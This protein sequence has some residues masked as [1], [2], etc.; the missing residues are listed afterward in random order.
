VYYRYKRYD[1]KVYLG[2]RR[3]AT[4]SESYTLN[5]KSTKILH[6]CTNGR[7]TMVAGTSKNVPRRTRRIQLKDDYFIIIIIIIFSIWNW[8]FRCVQRMTYHTIALRIVVAIGARLMVCRGLREP[9]EIHGIARTRCVNTVSNR[10]RYRV[11][12]Y[13]NHRAS[14]IH[15]W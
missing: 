8:E 2:F 15:Y 10:V 9:R 14:V 11:Y 4:R 7:I 5:W 13:A 12:L 3:L 6:H 1:T